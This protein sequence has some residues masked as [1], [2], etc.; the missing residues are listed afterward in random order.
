MFMKRTAMSVRDNFERVK[1]RVAQAALRSGRDPGGIT[2]IAVTKTHGPGTVIE[3]LEAGITDLGENRIQEFL[4][5]AGGVG[6]PCR[7]H[8][9]GHLQTNKV[10]KAVGRFAM[11]HSVD[12]IRLAEKIGQ[13]GVRENQV[14]DI[15]LEVNTSGEESKFGLEP[16]DALRLCEE[17]AGVPG[18]RLRGLM[19]VGP[20]VRDASIVSRAFG[21]LRRLAEE[22][23][24]AGI[25]NIS[26]EHLSMGMSDDF[27]IAI[28]EGSTMVRLGRVIFGPREGA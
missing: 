2:I 23:D 27:E 19:T 10:G 15:L 20:W 4:E 6:V 3:A 17:I 7:W 1:E 8:L 9:I 12:S 14:T 26:M 22:I 21:G 28:A 18:I 13:A 11:I 16:G 25:E 5:K 24:S